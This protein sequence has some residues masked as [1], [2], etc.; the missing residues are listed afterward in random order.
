MSDAGFFVL[1]LSKIDLSFTKPS[2]TEADYLRID[3]EIVNGPT[4]LKWV[5]SGST[6][7]QTDK[8]KPFVQESIPV[9]DGEET[10]TKYILG[11]TEPGGIVALVRRSTYISLT[12]EAITKLANA[13][14]AL[15]CMVVREPPAVAVEVKKGAPP[16]AA[17]VAEELLVEVLYYYPPYRYTCISPYRYTCISHLLIT[18]PF[19]SILITILSL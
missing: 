12:P 13:T 1:E 16:V 15:K 3:C 6:I 9:N 7:L 4:D 11:F 10:T 19:I 8:I 2:L 5:T 17:V 18:Y 14:L